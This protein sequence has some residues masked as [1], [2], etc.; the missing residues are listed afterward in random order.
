MFTGLLAVAPPEEAA[1]GIPTVMCMWMPGEI[2][3]AA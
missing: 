3:A 2:A 1:A